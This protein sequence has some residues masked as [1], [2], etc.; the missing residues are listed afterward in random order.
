MNAVMLNKFQ[1]MNHLRHCFKRKQGRAILAKQ[2]VCE[3]APQKYRP[4]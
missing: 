1:F 3:I 4:Q 2:P